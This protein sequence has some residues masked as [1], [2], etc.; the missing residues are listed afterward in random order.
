ML[1]WLADVKACFY[2]QVIRC[3]LAQLTAAHTDIAS[4]SMHVIQPLPYHDE[5]VFRHAVLGQVE[6]KLWFLWCFWNKTQLP[7]SIKIKASHGVR[8]SFI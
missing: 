2:L 8:Y 7:T 4:A 5:I 1:E 6:M 3:S